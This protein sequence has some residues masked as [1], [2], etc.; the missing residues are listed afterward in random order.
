MEAGGSRLL[1]GMDL[2]YCRVSTSRQSLE[3]QLDGLTGA[4]IP[5]QRI[6]QDD[7]EA[8]CNSRSPG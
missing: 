7:H 6:T 3:R 2:G 1:R 4:G 5:K 8:T